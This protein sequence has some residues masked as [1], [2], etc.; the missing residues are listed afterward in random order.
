MSVYFL[1]P[2]T[3]TDSVLDSSTVAEPAASETEWVLAGI[4]AIG[5]KRIRTA[6]HRVYECVLGHTGRTTAPEDDTAYWVDAGPTL[7][8][9]M[10]DTQ[11]STQTTATTSM[12]VVLRPGFANAVAFFG[13]DAASLQLTVKD[14]PG[15]TTVFSQTYD[16][17]DPPLDWWD[18]AFGTIKP[19]TKLVVS[20]LTPYPDAEITIVLSSSTGVTVKCGMCTV[21]DY[22]NLLDGA[23]WGGTQYGVSA[24]P[25]DYS[26]IKTDEFGNTTIVR[27]RNA[28]DLRFEVVMPRTQADLALTTLQSIL[29]TPVAVVLTTASGF[30]GLTAF[31]LVSGSMTYDN[32]TTASYRGTVKGLV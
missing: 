19:L 7:R 31:G 1:V 8:W 24:E 28:T 2:T 10:F 27:R 6:T 15:G 23:D 4:Y 13:L 29:A 30:S 14:A 21:G 20:G 12:T 5:D 17:T 26:Y 3:V 22:R 16:L 25:V 9:A 11:V 32:F 18:W